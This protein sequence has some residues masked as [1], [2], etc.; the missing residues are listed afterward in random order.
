MTKN[1]K[2]FIPISFTTCF[3]LIHKLFTDSTTTL[4]G[5]TKGGSITVLLTSCLTGLDSS[6]LQI[7]TNIASSHTAD[8]RPFKQE[9]NA[10]VILP[11]LVFPV[12]RNVVYEPLIVCDK[13]EPDKKMKSI[14]ENG[15]PSSFYVIKHVSWCLAFFRRQETI[16]AKKGRVEKNIRQKALLLFLVYAM[17]S[18]GVLYW[19]QTSQDIF[20]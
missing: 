3:Q 1:T 2:K 18:I 5:N 8:S 11:P 17:S 16:L 19:P 12:F 6:V 14:K 4:A 20:I 9:V 13:K 15:L 7:K 10:T